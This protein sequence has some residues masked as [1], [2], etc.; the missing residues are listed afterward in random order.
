MSLLLIY[1][2]LGMFVN[3]LT[4]DDKHFLLNRNNLTQPIQIQLSHKQKAFS[5]FFFHF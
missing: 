3:T 1:K 2:I 5:Q 4:G